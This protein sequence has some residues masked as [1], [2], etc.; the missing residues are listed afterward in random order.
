M[1]PINA[2][3]NPI[4]EYIVLGVGMAIAGAAVAFFG[5]ALLCLL[6]VRKALVGSL[7]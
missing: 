2:N 7:V 4:D 3:P 5:C 6:G 1:H